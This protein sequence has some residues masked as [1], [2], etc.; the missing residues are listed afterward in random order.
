MKLK[1]K[2]Q[3]VNTLILLISGGGGTKF[4]W[5]EIQSQSVG[6]R[7]KERPSIDCPTW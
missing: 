6:Q 1:K 3:S 2:D 7:L 5:E 4:P